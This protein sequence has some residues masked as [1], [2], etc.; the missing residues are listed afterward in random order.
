MSTP[1]IIPLDDVVLANSHPVTLVQRAAAV[2]DGA[3]YV[4][5]V[6]T[7]KSIMAY[8]IF[9]TPRSRVYPGA[10]EG[11]VRDNDL[12]MQVSIPYM[13]ANGITITLD[14]MVAI[15]GPIGLPE[16]YEITDAL[17]MARWNSVAVYKLR[18]WIE[19]DE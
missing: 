5:G 3:K 11:E 9:Q 6:R 19:Y 4:P 13:T 14:D 2:K 18:K 1:F 10:M 16:L 8:I 17:D 15:T 7:E 12:M